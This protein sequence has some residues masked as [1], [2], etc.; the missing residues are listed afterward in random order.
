MKKLDRPLRLS[1]ETLIRLDQRHHLREAAGGNTLVGGPC[2]PGS[3]P[4]HD[5]IPPTE[6]PSCY[7]Q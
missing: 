4:G 5:C 1:R 2:N 3:T 6:S 7:C